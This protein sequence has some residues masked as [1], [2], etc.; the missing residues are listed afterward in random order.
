MRNGAQCTPLIENFIMLTCMV[1]G[2]PLVRY[3]NGVGVK[4]VANVQVYALNRMQLR[5]ITKNS[6]SLSQIYT[7]NMMVPTLL[8]N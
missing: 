3:A 1:I 6:L 2:A 4:M 8:R 5:A 7:K